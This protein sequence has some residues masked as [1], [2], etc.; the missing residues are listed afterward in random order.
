MEIEVY[1]NKLFNSWVKYNNIRVLVDFDDTL[2]P[3]NTASKEFCESVISIL[4]EAQKYNAKI[5]LW[6]CRSGERLLS[7]IKYCEEKDLKFDEVNPTNPF[8]VGYS[9]KAYGNIQLDD[10]AG[11]EQALTILKL[12]LYK[13]KKFVYEINEKQRLQS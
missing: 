4:K 12:A 2:K 5:I 9:Q 1:V 10:K 13:Y 7:A 8:L 3:F 6:T 11:L